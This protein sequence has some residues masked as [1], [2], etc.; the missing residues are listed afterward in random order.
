[1]VFIVAEAGVNHNGSV[2]QAKELIDAAKDCGCDAIKFQAWKAEH[3]ASN[4]AQ[5]ADYQK[6]Q[7][8][9]SSQYEMLSKLSLE[10]EDHI[11]LKQYCFDKG[12]QYLCSPFDIEG[13]EMLSDFNMSKVKVPSGEITNLPYLRNLSKYKWDIILSTGMSDMSEIESAISILNCRDRITLLHCTSEYPAPYNEVNL[14][15]IKTMHNRFQMPIGYS[16]HTIGIEVAIAAVAI[17]ASIIEKHITLDTGMNGP[18]HIASTEPKMFKRMVESI[19]NI[20]LAMGNGIK[21]SQ[22]SEDKN[23]INIRKSIY[24]TTDILEGQLIREKMITCKRP[25]TGMS[26][27]EWDTI[28]GSQAKRTYKAGEQI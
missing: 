14:N 15:C 1:M 3:L 9:A 16:D 8:A 19:R 26:P 20:Q 12:I 11:M 10:K 21:L 5:L 17:G 18:D 7:V 23:K 2:S 25:A 22:V 6:S 24:A 27:M 4:D 13:I 28:V